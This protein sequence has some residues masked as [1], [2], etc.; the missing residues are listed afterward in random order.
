M[1]SLSTPVSNLSL[2][3]KYSDANVPV[4]LKYSDTTIQIFFSDITIFRYC[5]FIETASKLS[6]RNL[7]QCVWRI[8]LTKI[9]CSR[10]ICIWV[11]CSTQKFTEFLRQ[12][13]HNTENYNKTTESAIRNEIRSNW[14]HTTISK[15]NT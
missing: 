8:E 2:S 9:Q 10:E 4:N 11:A 13:T 15:S 14:K 6:V 5:N 3:T 1:P 7:M 12:K